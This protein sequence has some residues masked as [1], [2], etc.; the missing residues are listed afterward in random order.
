M[1]ELEVGLSA[2]QSSEWRPTNCRISQPDPQTWELPPQKSPRSKDSTDGRK[3][4]NHLREEK[5]TLGARGMVGRVVDWW[6]RLEG[7]QP[8][9][10]QQCTVMLGHPPSQQPPWL[11]A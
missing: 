1:Y 9:M 10:M 3:K 4:M 2:G 5:K 11:Q 6:V 7:R 8:M